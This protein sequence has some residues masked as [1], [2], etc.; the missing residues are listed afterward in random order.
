[1]SYS[2]V[3][4]ITSPWRMQA[5][6]GHQIDYL[7]GAPAGTPTYEVQ[8]PPMTSPAMYNDGMYHYTSAG[9]T[10]ATLQSE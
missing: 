8:T 6:D 1:M 2:Y 3:Q 4:P 9:G 10:D 5:L 7:D